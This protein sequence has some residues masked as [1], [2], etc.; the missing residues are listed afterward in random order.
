MLL[1]GNI[2][3]ILEEFILRRDAD[4]NKVLKRESTS[5]S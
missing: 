3:R 1:K 5:I 2:L 4:K